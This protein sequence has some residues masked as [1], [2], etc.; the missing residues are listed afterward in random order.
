MRP[1]AL[2]LYCGGG[3]VSM[4]LHRAGFDVLGVDLN[5]QRNYPFPFVQS[6]A[7]TY[8]REYGH[9]FDLITTSPTCQVH[10][11]LAILSGPGHLDLIPPTR[12]ALIDSGRPYTIENVENHD[13]RRDGHG[14]LVNPIVLCGSMFG[15]GATCRDGRHR[16]L[17]RHRL[18]E[19][20]FAIPQPVDACDGQLV[21]GVYGDGGGGPMTRGYKF[22][23]AESRAAMGIDWMNR[24]ELSQAIPPAY[25]EYIGRAAL[26]HLMRVA[27]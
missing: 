18:I 19:S 5:P 23:A 1:R 20:N 14:P 10:S 17:K 4:G 25:G 12:A 22:Y 16:I 2:D 15:L 27:A 9:L 3:G 21:G 6:D 8:L 26:A 24:P 13:Y 11:D 7:V